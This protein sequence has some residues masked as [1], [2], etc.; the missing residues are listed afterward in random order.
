LEAYHK[1][2]TI[3]ENLNESWFKYRYRHYW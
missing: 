2:Q 1:Y 3:L